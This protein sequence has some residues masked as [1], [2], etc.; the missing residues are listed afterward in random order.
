M[1]KPPSCYRCGRSGGLL[2]FYYSCVAADCVKK[3]CLT[4]EDCL[5][6]L[7]AG[8]GWYPTYCPACSVGRLRAFNKSKDRVEDFRRCPPDPG[9]TVPRGED[10]GPSAAARAWDWFCFWYVMTCIGLGILGIMAILWLS[11]ILQ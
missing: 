8:G 1:R 4:C 9:S 11:V 2:T 10:G 3:G 7:G 5:W 6:D